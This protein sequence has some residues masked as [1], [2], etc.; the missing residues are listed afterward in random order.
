MY[1]RL[2]RIKVGMVE[3]KVVRM[4][5]MKVV[6]MVEMKVVWMVVWMVETKG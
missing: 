5:E 6:R 1:N 3:M 4:V 2:W